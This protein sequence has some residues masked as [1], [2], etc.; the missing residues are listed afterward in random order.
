MLL[1][2]DAEKSYEEAEYR[3]L[4]LMLNIRWVMNM[5]VLQG[6]VAA[7]VSNAFVV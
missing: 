2:G 5:V 4:Q 3:Q 7:R 1:G 6:D